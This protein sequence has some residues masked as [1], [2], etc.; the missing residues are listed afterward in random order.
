MALRKLTTKTRMRIE[1]IIHRITIDNH[2][3]LKER[4]ELDKYSKHI[5]FIKSKLEKAL[6]YREWFGTNSKN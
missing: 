3:S 6:A 1:E 5:P 2:V 4:I